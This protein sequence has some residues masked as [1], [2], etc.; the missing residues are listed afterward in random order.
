M[1][2]WLGKAIPRKNLNHGRGA[3]DRNERPAVKLAKQITWEKREPGRPARV[4]LRYSLV[5][6]YEHL[7]SSPS[8]AG[9]GLPLAI[10][11]DTNHEPLAADRRI[12][13]RDHDL[14]TG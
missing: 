2:D 4:A 7:E 6:R 12:N 9:C 13:F 3:K 1:F 10:R 5:I 14:T 11:P 8:Q